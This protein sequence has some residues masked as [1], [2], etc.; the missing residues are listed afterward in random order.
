MATFAASASRSVIVV[1]L[2]HW[3]LLYLPA[4]LVE[5]AGRALLARPDVALAAPLPRPPLA[6]MVQLHMHPHLQGCQLGRGVVV[7]VGENPLRAD[8]TAETVGWHLDAVHLHL[9]APHGET[10][11]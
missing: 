3:H 10:A 1:G 11:A 9:S 4:L 2:R 5:A 8:A 7:A 6:R